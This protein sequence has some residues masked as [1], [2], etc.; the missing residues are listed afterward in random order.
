M[1]VDTDFLGGEPIFA[2]CE[3]AQPLTTFFSLGQR[4]SLP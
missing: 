4:K 3:N 1:V 2:S